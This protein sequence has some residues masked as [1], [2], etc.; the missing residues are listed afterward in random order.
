MLQAEADGQ[1]HPAELERSRVVV[2]ARGGGVGP[3][4][5]PTP[6]YDTCRKASLNRQASSRSTVL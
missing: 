5:G 2:W 1:Y 6:E 4:Q 3:L